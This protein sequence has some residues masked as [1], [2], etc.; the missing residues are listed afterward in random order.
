[1]D[2][3]HAKIVADFLLGNLEHEIGLTTG[4]FDAVPPNKLD[5]RPDPLS[6]TA[7]G[8]LRHITLEDEWLL[9]G[10]ASGSFGPPPGDSD[11]CGIMNAADAVSRYRQTVPAA[12][13]RVR[14]LPAD[15]L[16]DVLDLLGAVQAPAVNFNAS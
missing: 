14:A 13:A 7:L 16:L 11:A 9:N 8:L 1:M 15:R 3:Q 5:Y 4:V 10:I 6:K 12:L 2:P